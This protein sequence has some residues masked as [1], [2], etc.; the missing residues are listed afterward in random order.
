M[1]RVNRL[2]PGDTGFTGL[3]KKTKQKMETIIT[4]IVFET[5]LCFTSL[6]GRGVLQLS[7]VCVLLR[8]I[9]SMC[10]PPLHIVAGGVSSVSAA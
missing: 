4:E 2:R 1:D 3:T 10:M 8:P 6:E 5:G 9:K 7:L